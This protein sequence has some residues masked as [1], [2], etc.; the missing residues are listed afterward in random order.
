MSIGQ[1]N[2]KSRRADGYARSYIEL[3]SGT[4][5]GRKRPATLGRGGGFAKLWKRTGGDAPVRTVNI[6]GSCNVGVTARK[7]RYRRPLGRP[8]W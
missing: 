7:A 3:N 5:E 1:D 4:R 6:S 8:I 2:M